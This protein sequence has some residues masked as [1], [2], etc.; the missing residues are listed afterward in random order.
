MNLWSRRKRTPRSSKNFTKPIPR[1]SFLRARNLPT[2]ADP[3]PQFAVVSTENANDIKFFSVKGFGTF[4]RLSADGKFLDHAAVG[5]GLTKIMRQSVGGGQPKEIFTLPKERI[6]NFAWSAD[7]K[8]LAVSRGH[9]Y[10]DAIL[11]TGFE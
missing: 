4:A 2:A 6:F 8:K 5:D 7:G 9:Q 10:R 3:P 1:R 11:L